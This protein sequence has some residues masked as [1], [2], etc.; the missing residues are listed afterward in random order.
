MRIKSLHNCKSGSEAFSILMCRHV[1]VTPPRTFVLRLYFL[2]MNL[3]INAKRPLLIGARRSKAPLLRTVYQHRFRALY[4]QPQ[5]L[6]WIYYNFR[7]WMDQ[8]F[9]NIP[10]KHN[11]F[12]R[13][14]PD[15]RK[16]ILGGF[17]SIQRYSQNLQRVGASQ[18]W[19]QGRSW[20]EATIHVPMGTSARLAF[21]WSAPSAD[22][23]TG[24][25][26]RVW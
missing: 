10:N 23:P 24:V 18:K 2:S 19:F 16:F 26:T 11:D 9:Q 5:L 15:F 14:I 12:L 22:I 21:I 17:L 7:Q 8:H 4:I 1:I 13:Y 3:L 6:L 20:R 25:L